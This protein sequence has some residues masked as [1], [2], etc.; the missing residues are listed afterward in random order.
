MVYLGKKITSIRKEI[1]HSVAF[2]ESAL[3]DPE[4]YCVDGF[5]EELE[6]QIKDVI[7]QLQRFFSFSR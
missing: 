3:D 6:I 7:T 4:H 1:I 2:I 5:S